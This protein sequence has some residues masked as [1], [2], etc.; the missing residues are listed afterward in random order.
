MLSEINLYIRA[1]F[2]LSL[3]HMKEDQSVNTLCNSVFDT[4]VQECNGYNNLL[5]LTITLFLN[6]LGK[7]L[8]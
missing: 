2:K 1:S 6:C 3:M 8:H 5:Y 4:R 7:S